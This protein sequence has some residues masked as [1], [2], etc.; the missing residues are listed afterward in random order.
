MTSVTPTPPPTPSTP[1]TPLSPPTPREAGSQERRTATAAPAHPLESATTPSGLAHA[2]AQHCVRT[3][4]LAGASVLLLEPRE[5]P[6]DLLEADLLEADLPGAD[7]LGVDLLEADPARADLDARLPAARALAREVL[8]RPSS[9]FIE[10]AGRCDGLVV[11]AASRGRTEDM[12]SQVGATQGPQDTTPAVAVTLYAVPLRHGDEEVGALTV[13]CADP[14][15]VSERGLT[16]VHTAAQV[17]AGVLARLRPC[18][19]RGHRVDELAATLEARV[20]VAQATGVIGE[21][22]DVGPTM[23]AQILQSA[24]TRSGRPLGLVAREIVSRPRRGMLRPQG[25]R[26]WRSR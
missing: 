18:S 14:D 11:A 9:R 25:D 13:L 2:L 26:F 12:P 24:A 10:S 7:L 20:L 8:R 6:A 21:R 17:A 15:G 23:A 3:I 4:G 16:L 19:T 1:S 5:C 22:F